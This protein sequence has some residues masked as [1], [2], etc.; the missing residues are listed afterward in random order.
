MNDR[1]LISGVRWTP[2]PVPVTVSPMSFTQETL[3]IFFRWKFGLN[4]NDK[5][6]RNDTERFATQGKM[7]A[8]RPEGS[9]EPV[10]M[11]REGNKYKLIEGFHRTMS[12][13]LSAHDPNKGAPADQIRF[14]Q[15]GGNVFDLDLKKWQPVKINA[16]VGVRQPNA[17]TFYSWPK[18]TPNNSK[19]VTT[20]AHASHGPAATLA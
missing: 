7:A 4:P 20:S 10:I 2:K 19:D 6:V 13:L 15:Q 9:N 17:P 18:P 11:I 3:D 12:Y 14:L 1:D 5:Q 8:E 16:Y